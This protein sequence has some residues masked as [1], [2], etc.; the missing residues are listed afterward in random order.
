MQ[1]SGA[2]DTTSF[3][4]GSILF[5]CIVR[6]LALAS[7]CILSLVKVRI[8][9]PVSN[10]TYAST[11]VTKDASFYSKAIEVL[12]NI[13]DFVTVSTYLSL[14]VVW[15][16]TFQHVRRCVVAQC[17]PAGRL[18][19]HVPYWSVFLS[20]RHHVSVS[21]PSLLGSNLPAQLDGCVPGIQ[22]HAVR[23]SNLFVPAVLFLVFLGVLPQR[24]L[25]HAC[26]LEPCCTLDVSRHRS[27]AMCVANWGHH[28]TGAFSPVCLLVVAKLCVFWLP[29]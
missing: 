3:F 18:C 28:T 2:W 6:C 23:W 14:V 7:L 20:C 4:V 12:F 15:V 5:A 13:G 26:Y 27:W 17:C 16:E 11:P 19:S 9:G 22:C 21:P 1:A 24:D 8:S 29:V 10:D 25:H